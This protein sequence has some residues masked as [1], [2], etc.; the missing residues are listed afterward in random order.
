MP[1]EEYNHKSETLQEVLEEIAARIGCEER[2]VQRSSKMTGD[3]FTQ[4]MVLGCLEQPETSLNSLAQTSA[5]LGVDIT[6]SGINQRIDAEAVDL[7]QRILKEAVE[8]FS[9]KHGVPPEI[10]RKF[11][12]V[13]ILDS[14]QVTLPDT[15]QDVFAGCGGDGPVAGAKIHLSYEYLHGEV[16]AIEIVDGR[17]PDQNC[18]LHTQVTTPGSLHLFDLGYFKQDVFADLDAAGAYFI[19]RYQRQTAL[20][21][22][23]DVPIG[24]DVLAFVES[25]RGNQ[26]QIVAHIG[27]KVQL[28][29]RVLFQRLPPDVVEERRRKV[30]AKMRRDG[31][32]PSQR[33]LQL[34]EWNI[35]ITNVPEKWLSFEQILLVYRV[36]WQIEIIFKVWKSD[37]HLDKIGSWRIERVLCQLYA[38]LTGLMLFHW[39]IAPYRFAKS[40]ELSLSKAFHV[41]RR[42]IPRLTEA[43]AAG[44][45]QVAERLHKLQRDLLRFARKD[46]RKKSPSTFQRL[47]CMGA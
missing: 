17:S 15:L 10:M 13:R 18:S 5:D 43:I 14:T 1:E 40:V 31:K 19:S 21:W 42:H 25:I 28:S 20:Y 23:E 34:L 29:V 4:M 30:R 9:G 47:V 45:T 26:C 38:R 37:A 35:F 6:E 12:A 24:F 39:L 7:M 11:S 44:W 36:R 46:K 8:R 41:L 27:R 16:T 32:T 2:F 33:Y 3:H 22:Q